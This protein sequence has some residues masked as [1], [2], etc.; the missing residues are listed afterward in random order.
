MGKFDLGETW[1]DFSVV[2]EAGVI[3]ISITADGRVV[4][5]C[6]DEGAF[7]IVDVVSEKVFQITSPRAD[8]MEVEEA[9]G[10]V[11]YMSDFGSNQT[12]N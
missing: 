11:Y 7:F 4:I 10:K 8:T 5:E 1:A 9:N 6:D 2:T 12:E 3:S